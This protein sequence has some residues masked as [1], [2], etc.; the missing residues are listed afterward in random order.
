MSP[1]RASGSSNI[2]SKIEKY[3]LIKFTQSRLIP[4]TSYSEVTNLLIETEYIASIKDTEKY[5]M[6]IPLFKLLNT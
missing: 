1:N 5:S 2:L 6:N 4:Q 3:L